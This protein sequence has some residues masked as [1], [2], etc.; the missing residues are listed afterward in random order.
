MAVAKL[1]E[2]RQT[3][4]EAEVSYLLVLISRGKFGLTFRAQD[5]VADL[6]CKSVYRETLG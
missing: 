1:L 4:I 2:K 6:Q 3:E 5:H